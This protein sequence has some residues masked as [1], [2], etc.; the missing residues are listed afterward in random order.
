LKEKRIVKKKKT[1]SL[2]LRNK[3]NKRNHEARTTYHAL[4]LQPD[5]KGMC[6]SHEKVGEPSQTKK[7]KKTKKK[8]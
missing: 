8:E 4:H 7:K 6:P 5:D 3:K 2:L 1:A